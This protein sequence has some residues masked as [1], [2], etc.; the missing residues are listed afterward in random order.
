MKAR[1]GSW[2]ARM[3]ATGAILAERA[4]MPADRPVLLPAA[5]S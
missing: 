1:G 5:Q 4:T 3:L 2:V